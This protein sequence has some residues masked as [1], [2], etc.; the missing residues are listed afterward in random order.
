MS[1]LRI[2]TRADQ[3]ELRIERLDGTPV[4]THRIPTDARPTIHPITGPDGVGIMTEDGPAHHPWQHGLYTGFNVVNGVGF[5]RNEPK[6]GSFAPKLTSPPRVENGVAHWSLTNLWRH[7]DG[8]L[9]ITETQDWSLRADEGTYVIDL[10]WGL[11]AEIDI[12]IGEFMAGGL[13]LR[14]PYLP[15][16]GAEALNSNGQRDGDA[17]KQRARWTA[18]A[19]P[20]DGRSDWAGM[21]IMDHPTN[22][23]HPTTWRVDGEFGISPSR[24]IAGSWDI[25]KGTTEAYTFRVHVFCGAINADTVETVWQDFISE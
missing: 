12:K 16:S 4:L 6:D 18:V 14:M 22:P 8:T 24:V 10:K 21:A 19:M 17:E 23:A 25:P 2:I 3:T 1:D 9:M 7:P 13:F 20:I 5:W 15:E 11:K